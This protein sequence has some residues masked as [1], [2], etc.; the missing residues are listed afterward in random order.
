MV[1]NRHLKCITLKIRLNI[2]RTQNSLNTLTKFLFYSI[3][4]VIYKRGGTL[5]IDKSVLERKR[6]RVGV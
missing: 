3:F 1:K 2:E 4:N 6:R 5:F